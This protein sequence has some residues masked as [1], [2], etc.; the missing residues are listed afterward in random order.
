MIKSPSKT[1]DKISPTVQRDFNLDIIRIIA[2]IFIPCL[3]FF[4]HMGFYKIPI[5]HPGMMFLMCMRNI[6]LTCIPLF[7]I[8]TGYLQGTKDFVPDKKYYVKIFKFLIPY[9]IVCILTLILEGLLKKSTPSIIDVIKGFTTYTGYTWYIEMYLGLFLFMPFLNKLYNTLKTKKQEKLLL[10]L[11][12]VFTLLPTVIN[13][14]SF[15]SGTWFFYPA[16]SSE[17]LKILP[18]FWAPVY[19]L[20]FYFTGTYIRRHKDEIKWSSKK[21]FLILLTAVVIFSVYN[22]IRNYGYLPLV[23]SWI[24]RNSFTQYITAVLIFI[25]VLTLKFNGVSPKLARLTGK[26]ADLTFSAYIC[27]YLADKV[28]YHFIKKNISGF[29]NRL[30]TYPITVLFIIVCSLVIAFFVDTITKK[31]CKQI[32]KL[33]FKDK[34]QAK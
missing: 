9:L 4:L 22:I 19:P 26:I 2:F 25:F 13:T 20:T 14:Y 23:Y 7:M 27:S 6:F 21:A 10:T 1:P 31:L 30:Y 15:T 11:L 12:I 28:V 16:D 5:T 18:D 32:N 33:I 8:L 3:H 29:I 34:S 17:T 24:D